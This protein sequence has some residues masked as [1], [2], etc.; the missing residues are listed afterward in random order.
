VLILLV[1]PRTPNIP[2]FL[3]EELEDSDYSGAEEDESHY[4]SE[5]EEYSLNTTQP[6]GSFVHR[7]PY[8]S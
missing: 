2:D 3:E 7:E 5:D 1:V 4:S 8:T 6:Y